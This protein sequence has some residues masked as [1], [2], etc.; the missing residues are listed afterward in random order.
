MN[1]FFQCFFSSPA[2]ELCF[3]LLKCGE[4]DRERE[5]L[6]AHVVDVNDGDRVHALA[7]FIVYIKNVSGRQNHPKALL[8]Y[9]TNTCAIGGGTRSHWCLLSRV[10]RASA[11]QRQTTQHPNA[12]SFTILLKLLVTATEWYGVKWKWVGV[13]CTPLPAMQTAM[14]IMNKYRKE[15]KNTEK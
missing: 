1:S 7:R 13:R 5:L 9:K 15:R 10:R 11:P 3:G 14:Q 12:N 6:V 8:E 4:R 2:S